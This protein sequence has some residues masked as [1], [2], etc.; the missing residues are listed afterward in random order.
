MTSFCK[1]AFCNAL[2][3]TSLA[4]GFGIGVADAASDEATKPQAHS[5]GV[6][7]MV[8]D[9]AITAKVKVRLMGE[10]SLKK[11]DIDVTTTNGVVTL[12]GSASSSDAKSTAETAA[13]SVEGV[14]SVDNNLRSPGSS[15]TLA[16]TKRVV[17]DSWI[18]TKVKS[19]ILADSI[20]KGFE[21]H[22]KTIRGVVV[23]KGA[24]ANQDAID[25]VKD[26]AQSVEGVKSVDTSDLTVA[27]K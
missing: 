20:S 6:V 19:E 2:I 17:S 13:K 3:A 27:G 11:S 22:V 15:K 24:L 5:D 4:V 10:D 9:T 1:N 14:K 16:K 18:T 8:T 26:I 25:H 23:L 7:A 21:V 12:K